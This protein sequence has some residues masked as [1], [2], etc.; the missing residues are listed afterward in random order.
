M[1]EVL[2]V[3]CLNRH[4]V[5]LFQKLCVSSKDFLERFLRM[6]NKIL[7]IACRFALVKWCVCSTLDTNLLKR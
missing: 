7:S 6:C 3:A 5:L 2:L 4:F 1:S